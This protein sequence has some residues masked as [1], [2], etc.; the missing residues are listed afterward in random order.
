VK[1]P[2]AAVKGDGKPNEI[3]IQEI[4]STKKEYLEETVE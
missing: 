4:S 2:K 3:L 1:Q